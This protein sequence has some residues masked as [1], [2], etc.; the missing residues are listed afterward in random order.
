[1][2]VG[3]LNEHVGVLIL[4]AGLRKPCLVVVA[5]LVVHAFHTPVDGKPVGVHVEKAHENGYHEARLVEILVFLHFFHHH[6]LAVGRGHHDFLNKVL[7]KIT[8]RATEEIEQ[9]AVYHSHHRY[10]TPKRYLGVK[11][12]PQQ[13]GDGNYNEKTEKKR[14]G[15]LTVQPL[16]L[17][18][19]HLLTHISQFIQ[20]V[21]KG[22]DFLFFKQIF[23]TS[24]G[25]IGRMS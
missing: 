8:Y 7:V 18:F 16:L 9:Y 15:A 19:P 5:V 22:N 3:G 25:Y 4:L 10:K 12:P 14:V 6:H 24:F 21:G 17:E 2:A 23:P 11:T 13:D 1:M 20:I